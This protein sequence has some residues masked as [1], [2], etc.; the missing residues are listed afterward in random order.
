M[1]CSVCW[2]HCCEN[3]Y[4]CKG[5]HS[6]VSEAD[7]AATP[8]PR[9]PNINS[10]Q[11]SIIHLFP[12]VNILMSPEHDALLNLRTGSG[13]CRPG[14]GNNGMQGLAI[15]SW[16]SKRKLAFSFSEITAHLLNKLIIGI[17]IIWRSFHLFNISDSVLGCYTLRHQ[18]LWKHGLEFDTLSM[19]PTAP[20]CSRVKNKVQV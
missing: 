19:G 15:S 9:P 11:I 14:H 10:H 20:N 17:R 16:E 7:S 12:P 1:S 6:L 5:S 13:S 4:S 8:F 18:Q 3:N 2:T